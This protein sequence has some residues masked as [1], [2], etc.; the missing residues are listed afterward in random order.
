M[1]YLPNKKKLILMILIITTTF[2]LSNILYLAW[3]QIIPIVSTRGHFD[4]SSGILLFG[5]TETDYRPLNIPGL[6][7]G[8]CPPEIV[9]YV[10]GW[11]ADEESAIRQLNVVMNSLESHDIDYSH[12]VIGFSWDS[13]TSES[14]NLWDLWDFW[15]V[16]GLGELRDT[17]EAWDNG[18]DIATQ[19]GLKLGKFV[20]DFKTEC[21]HTKVRLL[22]HSL[23]ARVILNALGG[24]FN[25]PELALWNAADRN[26]KVESVHLLGAAVNPKDISITRGFGIPIREEV[27]QFHNKFSLQ[28]D[29]LEQNYRNAESPNIA[30]GEEGAQNMASGL[31]NKYHELDVSR[32]ISRDSDGD[33]RNNYLHLGDDHMGYAGVVN[34]NNG[35]LTS[36]GA[37]DL[38]VEDWRNNQ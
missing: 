25:E 23:G 31:G 19:N 17:L 13:D 10:H 18:K 27:N 9:V 30:L 34:R 29:V 38:V 3:G 7:V 15:D 24:L 26:Y 2:T 36:N 1:Q 11:N 33:G 12:P 4:L 37:M 6:Q 22:G 28:D 21:E 16:S 20:L 14:L 32:E 8:N 35:E 5:H